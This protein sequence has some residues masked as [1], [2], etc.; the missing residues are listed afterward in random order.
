MFYDL[1]MFYSNSM[2]ICTLNCIMSYQKVQA[3][4]SLSAATKQHTPFDF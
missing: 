4:S 3:E 1:Y 2:L